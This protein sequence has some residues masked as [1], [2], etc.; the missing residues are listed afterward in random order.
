MPVL[1]YTACTLFFNYFDLW[2]DI[3]MLIW[4]LLCFW[5]ARSLVVMLFIAG[6]IH[7]F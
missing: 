6:R 2:S 5:I 4:V 7:W 1:L 3:Y